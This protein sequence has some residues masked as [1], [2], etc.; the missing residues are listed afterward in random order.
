MVVSSCEI[1]PCPLEEQASAL[2]LLYR[3]VPRAIR[4]QAINEVLGS[5][6]RGELDLS[7]L[8]MARLRGRVVGAMLT[9]ILAGRAAAIWAP[10]VAIRWGRATTAAGLVHAA[11]VDFHGRGIQIAQALVD[12]AAPRREGA[13]LARGGLP[14]VTDLVYLERPTFPPLQV[15]LNCPSF[16]WERYAPETE[17]DFQKVLRATYAGSLDMPELEG[18]RSLDDIIASHQEGSRFNPERWQIGWLP[19]E[20]ASAAIL[21]LSELPDHKAWEVT[22]L[23]LTPPARGRGLGQSALAHAL[24]LASPF[25]PRLELAV[26]ARNTPAQR[27]YR[28]AGFVPFDRRAVHLAALNAF[29]P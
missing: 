22:Y 14:W 18:V 24:N 20:P 15:G 8:W 19:G 12:E 7:G 10:E 2:E 29:V 1:V 13:D 3:R 26:D 5:A 9:Q 16:H 4:S 27:L 6:R 23:G 28:A 11:L 21:L 25:T 17:Q